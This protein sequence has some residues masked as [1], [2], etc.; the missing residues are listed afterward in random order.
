[1]KWLSA[2]SHRNLSYRNNDNVINNLN[3]YTLLYILIQNMKWTKGNT[4]DM[5]AAD[6]LVPN[7]RTKTSASTALT[8]LIH[9]T[10]Y[11]SIKQFYIEWHPFNKQNK[12][13]INDR[14]IQKGRRTQWF[15]WKYL[16][17]LTRNC[18]TPLQQTTDHGCPCVTTATHVLSHILSPWPQSV[19]Q[20]AC[21]LVT[22]TRVV[23]GMIEFP[24]AVYRSR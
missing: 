22:S 24:V 4:I 17:A 9:G 13:K 15:L 19:S 20:W 10:M 14:N 21:V 1:M 3:T 5:V 18:N 23:P 6:A 8:P 2:N 7:A 16:V 12:L 11:S